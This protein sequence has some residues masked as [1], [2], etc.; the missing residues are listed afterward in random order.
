[1]IMAMKPR[2]SAHLSARAALG[3]CMVVLATPFPRA[4]IRSRCRGIALIAVSH[5][6]TPCQ[7]Q[8]TRRWRSR[9][10]K[11]SFPDRT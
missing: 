10:S 9:I 8:I 2:I 5:V 6:L 1:M 4:G 7:Y 3:V 11:L